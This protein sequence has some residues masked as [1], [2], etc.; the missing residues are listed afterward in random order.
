VLSATLHHGEAAPVLPVAT[1]MHRLKL[2]AI[3]IGSCLLLMGGYL[4][5]N[6]HAH[7]MRIAR[8]FTVGDASRP[9]HVLIATQGSAFKDALVVGIVAALQ[10]RP[11]YVQ[12]IDV[13]ALRD[14]HDDDWKAIIIAHTWE[15]G[16][17][18]AD[19]RAF[20]NRV[21]DKRKLIVVTTSGGGREKLPG[22][23][24]ISAAS[25]MDDT[26]ARVAEI[27]GRLDDIL[28]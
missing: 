14:V 5:W 6:E 1:V 24:A 11:I 4:L 13:S 3:I 23:D 28:Q 18:Q 17:G 16:R 10:S 12:V 15:F 22:I 2:I 26:P 7:A 21:P 19:A 25:I 27:I 9:Q 20:V 8:P